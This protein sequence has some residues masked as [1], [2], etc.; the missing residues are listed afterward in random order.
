MTIPKG[1]SL[2]RFAE[3]DR[4]AW[5][6]LVGDARNA[7]FF[8]RRDYLDYHGDRIQDHSMVLWR[9][10][11]PWAVLPAHRDGDALISHGG[12]S[13]GGLVVA[14]EA[15]YADVAGCFDLL[16][17]HMRAE[18]MARLTYRRAPTP[19]WRAP[20]EEDLLEL[21]RR[22]ARRTD[23]R[24]GA[25]LAPS[26]P[27]AIGRT[28]RHEV[29]RAKS[30]GFEVRPDPVE[31]AWPLV[32]DMLERRHRAAPVHSFE[33]ICLLR[34]HFPDNILARSVFAGSERLVSAVLFVSPSVLK[35]QYFGWRS[36]ASGT[37]AAELMDVSMAEEAR[38]GG[39]WLDLGTSM[40]PETGE[41]QA[42]LHATKEDCG[43]RM[44][45]YETYEWS[46]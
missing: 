7:H 11:R 18:G 23:V 38:R 25:A 21:S 37:G 13:F 8:F 29:K 6:N 33:E 44:I 22:G 35:M 20:G 19:Y 16:A 28:C 12:L 9:G 26:G 39:R 17:D 10:S 4:G 2:T 32:V 5:D 42:R 27:V 36:E 15:R 34:D 45:L 31:G 46:P 1:L 14:P 30:L 3:A 43:A 41:L 40:E 24:V